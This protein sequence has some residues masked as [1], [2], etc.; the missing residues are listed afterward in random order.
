MKKIVVIMN[1]PTFTANNYEQV[2]DDLRAAGKS[3]PNGLL[4]HVGFAKPGG[5]WMVVDV[6]ES[7]EAFA[8]FSKTLLPIIQKT[9]VAMEEPQ[10][11]PAHYFYEPHAENVMG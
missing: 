2:W 11:L 4:S 6:W 10:I 5:G 1:S 3:N 8:E 7:R 9:G